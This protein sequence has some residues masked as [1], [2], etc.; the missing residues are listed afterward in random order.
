M[1]S[2]LHEALL[3]LFRNRPQLA[4]V[5]L[6][7]GL[8]FDLPGYTD[9]RLESID[10]TQVVPTEYRADLIVL[11]L[12]DVPVLAII[13]EVQLAA[14]ER[15]RFTWPIYATTTR[16]QFECD[17]VVLVVTPTASV[18]RWASASC[19]LGGGNQWSA[20]VAGPEQIPVVTDPA[21]AQLDPELGVL[22]VMAHTG[23][24]SPLAP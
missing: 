4:A 21:R 15:K 23:K 19:A 1:P 22:S 18:A 5:L 9:A 24:G 3:L 17:T 12:H 14:D 13:V 20:W 7:E 2:L 6:Q 11:L 8:H 10:L 16:A